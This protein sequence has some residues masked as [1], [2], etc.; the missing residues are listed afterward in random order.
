[1]IYKF[2]KQIYKNLII[3]LKIKYFYSSFKFDFKIF[4]I[5]S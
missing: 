3:Y 5:N 2:N 1:M 4:V